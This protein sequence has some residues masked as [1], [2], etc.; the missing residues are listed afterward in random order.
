MPTEEKI[1][2]GTSCRDELHVPR[3]VARRLALFD[4]PAHIVTTLLV[5]KP[6]ARDKDSKPTV[7]PSV[8]AGI[9]GVRAMCAIC[10]AAFDAQVLKL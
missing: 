8:A 7:P 2:M 1:A 5:R 6:L 3:F 4:V 9:D 10:G